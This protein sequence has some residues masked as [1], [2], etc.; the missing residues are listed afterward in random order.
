MLM[1]FCANK[2]TLNAREMD[3]HLCI[4]KFLIENGA[5]KL[6]ETAKG[7]NAFTLASKHPCEK[8]SSLLTNI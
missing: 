1:Q 4:I 3:V 7:K 2:M 6:I 5:N 8:V